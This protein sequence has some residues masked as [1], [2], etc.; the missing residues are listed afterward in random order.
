MARV[1]GAARTAAQRAASTRLAA[2]G[3]YTAAV[4]ATASRFGIAP[5]LIEDRSALFMNAPPPNTRLARRRSEIE[6]VILAR[7]V[8]LYLGSIVFN[9]SVRSLAKAANLSAMG[10]CKAL[11]AVEDMRDDPQLDAVLDDLERELRPS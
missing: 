6:R 11:R 10:V 9:R 2:Y 4:A 8:S 7:R 5:E 3:A 1:S